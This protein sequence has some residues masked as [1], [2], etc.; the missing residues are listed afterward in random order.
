MK[1]ARRANR[2]GPV[3][4][5]KSKKIDSENEVS[6]KSSSSAE[7]SLNSSNSHR[8]GKRQPLGLLSATNMGNSPVSQTGLEVDEEPRKEALFSPPRPPR[9]LTAR[10]NKQATAIVSVKGAAVLSPATSHTSEEALKKTRGRPKKI[11]ASS[12]SSVQSS[13]SSSAEYKA[14]ESDTAGS[15]IASPPPKLRERRSSRRTDSVKTTVTGGED[16]SVSS[17]YSPVKKKTLKQQKLVAVQESPSERKS[18]RLATEK[19]KK[20]LAKDSPAAKP[21]VK[22]T[23]KR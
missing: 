20:E 11:T 14:P 4:A 1:P 2:G 22:P 16:S 13:V 19:K 9:R 5:S 15:S 17:C 7:S 6:A 8:K 10:G 12:S 23:R 18:V 3:V 21:T